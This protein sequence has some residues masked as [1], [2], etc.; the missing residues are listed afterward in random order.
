MKASVD[1]AKDE[2]EGISNR[3]MTSMD[4]SGSGI[5]FLSS[6]SIGSGLSNVKC[7]FA[8]LAW[9]RI[10]TYMY[11]IRWDCNR[12][13]CTNHRPA[14]KVIQ[15]ISDFERFHLRFLIAWIVFDSNIYKDVRRD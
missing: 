12:C 15:S 3:L 1:L 5:E 9:P 2:H 13:E 6:N 10:S 7:E 11:V 8:R 4:I 14:T